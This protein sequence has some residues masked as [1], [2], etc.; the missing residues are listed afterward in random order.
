MQR[1]REIELLAAVP[2]FAGCSKRELREIALVADELTVP[3]GTT[4]MR[5]GERGREFMVIESGTVSVTRDQREIARL[6]AGEWVGEIALVADVP[7][8]ATVVTVAETNIIVLT[9]RAFKKLIRDMPSIAEKALRSVG[10][11]LAADASL[12]H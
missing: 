7:R 5:Q 1:N 10:E 3:E 12:Q 8:T 6:G 11:R 4:L 9:D 2:L